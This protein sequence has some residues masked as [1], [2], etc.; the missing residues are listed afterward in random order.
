[1]KKINLLLFIFLMLVSN[2]YA[3]KKEFATKLEAETFMVETMKKSLAESWYVDSYKNNIV[4]IKST[5]VDSEYNEDDDNDLVEHKCNRY[6][7]INF[8]AIDS[9]VIEEGE[10]DSLKCY[11]LILKGKNVIQKA[12]MVTKNKKL[13]SSSFQDSVRLFD[14]ILPFAQKPFVV[15]GEN[16]LLRDNFLDAARA[17][18]KFKKEENN[19]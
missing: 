5:L 13:I 10:C 4:I 18:N 14:E 12:F 15:F 16:T 19:K 11:S 7:R 3:Q 9:I 17:F 1:M 2:L 8:Q 6:R